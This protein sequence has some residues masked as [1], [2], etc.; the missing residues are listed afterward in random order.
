MDDESSG[1]DDGEDIRVVR[2]RLSGMRARRRLKG[3]S[4]ILDAGAFPVIIGGDHSIG[5]PDA[6]ALAKHVDRKLGIVHFDRHTDTAVTT[7]DE[8]M[9]TTHWSHATKLPGF[10]DTN[11]YVNMLADYARDGDEPL[12]TLKSW[13]TGVESIKV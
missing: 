10:L 6:K 11:E 8:R 9:H 13:S 5:Y 3:G 4:H 7:M 1:K 12:Q 2:S